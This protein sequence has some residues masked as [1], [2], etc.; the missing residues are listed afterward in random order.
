M[1]NRNG[2]VDRTE[3]TCSEIVP[4]RKL[5]SAR[6][7][8]NMA[9]SM[10]ED[11]FYSPTSVKSKVWKYFKLRRDVSKKAFCTLCKEGINHEDG[12]TSAMAKH[13]K[14]KHKGSAAARDLESNSKDETSKG[15]QDEGQMLL[16]AL[17]K[18]KTPFGANEPKA[19]EITAKI[20]LMI[21]KDL[22]PISIIEDQGFRELLK[23]FESRYQPVSR[24]HLSQTVIPEYYDIAATALKHLLNKSD[25]YS[26]TADTWTS[27]AN[28]NYLTVT[29]HLLNDWMI[30]SYIL[31][32]KH[33]D[34]AHTAVN[35]SNSIREIL[36]EWLPCNSSYHTVKIEGSLQDLPTLTTDNA[37]NIVKGE[38]YHHKIFP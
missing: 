34:E 19:K 33:I 37:S 23:Y 22:Q 14:R 3:N 7:S 32:T 4:D 8:G 36:N 28:Q 9:T 5:C 35:L 18:S 1:P 6:I 20:A 29:I 16:P 21:V 2:L 26:M 15:S 30:T 17:L 27:R 24:K 11:V 12:N 25:S 13:I 10:D 38:L 31:A